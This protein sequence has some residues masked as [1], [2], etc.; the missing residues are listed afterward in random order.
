MHHVVQWV[1]ETLL[2]KV[3]FRTFHLLCKNVSFD[4]ALFDVV[5]KMIMCQ[6]LIVKECDEN[7]VI[8]YETTYYERICESMY[9]H[10]KI[11]YSYK[12]IDIH[13]SSLNFIFI[14]LFFPENSKSEF[15]II[16]VNYGIFLPSAVLLDLFR[17][18]KAIAMAS[19]L[20]FESLVICFQIIHFDPEFSLIFF[21][22]SD[23]PGG[24]IRYTNTDYRI[25]CGSRFMFC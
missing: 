18:Y 20:L 25:L 19:N 1:I 22:D 24:I 7:T 13:L 23:S 16:D 4:T 15:S 14:S 5:N 3:L 11:I 17:P 10:C 6:R 21:R 12:F 8:W 9:W 2:R